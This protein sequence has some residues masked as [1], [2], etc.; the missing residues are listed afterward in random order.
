[1]IYCMLPRSPLNGDL[2][3]VNKTLM[4]LE[5]W[6]Q[7]ST[8]PCSALLRLEDRAVLYRRSP[9][10]VQISGSSQND[11]VNFPQPVFNFTRS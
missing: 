1:M 11:S 4:L 8:G 10:Y 5:I 3:K 6:R 2:R 9:K 7:L